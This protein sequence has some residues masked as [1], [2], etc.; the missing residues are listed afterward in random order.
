MNLLCVL[1]T[2]L[3]SCFYTPKKI[4]RHFSDQISGLNEYI[5]RAFSDNPGLWNFN[6]L[7]GHKIYYK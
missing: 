2:K 4:F 7:I 6:D 1:H 5:C 3:L